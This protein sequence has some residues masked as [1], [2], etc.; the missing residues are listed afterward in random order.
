MKVVFVSNYLSHHQKPFCDA[1]Q[2]LCGEEFAFVATKTI[3]EK[4]IRMGWRSDPAPYLVPAYLGGEAEERALALAR[5]ADV[6]ILG[7]APDR[8][9]ARRLRAGRLTFRYSERLYKDGLDWKRLPRALAGAWLHHGRFQRRPVYMLCASAYTAGDCARFGNYLGR[10]YRWGYFPAVPRYSDLE[11]LLARKDRT[12]ILWAGRFLPLKHPEVCVEA[13][14]RLKAE[15]LPFTL[16]LIGSGE[17]EPELRRRVAQAGLEDRVRFLG[18]MPPEAVRTHMERAG[19]YL[20]TSGPQEGWGAVLNEAMSSACAVVASAAA[21]STPFL[22]RD[23]ENGCVYSGA[24][25][26]G[27]YRAVRAL[28]EDPDRQTRLGRRAYETM[29]GLWNP[30]TAARR[31]LA[32]SQAILDGDPAPALFAEGPCSPAPCIRED[33]YQV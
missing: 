28:L 32:L 2:A 30:E 26:E 29:A 11:D 12:A 20:F 13:A 5:E 33:W 31:I 14:R 18:T 1:M 16:E 15:G 19:I 23:G 17:L 8:Y 4:R 7:S 21:G 22:V 25:P 6:V 27:L 3:N 9:L 24:D 10:T